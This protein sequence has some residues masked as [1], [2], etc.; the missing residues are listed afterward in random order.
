MKGYFMEA[1]PQQISGFIADARILIVDDEPNIVELLTRLLRI[2]GYKDVRSIRDSRGAMAQI[3]EFHPDLLILDLMMPHIDGF[4]ILEALQEYNSDDGYLPVL[5]ITAND[6]VQARRRAFLGGAIEFLGKP[7]D[8][9]E[10]ILRVRTLLRLRYEYLRLE[11]NAD[12]LREEILDRTRELEDYQLV[13]KEAQIEVIVRLARA[14]EHR[15]D[16]TGQHT[17]RVG[18]IA[19]L[20]AQ[21]MELDVE[22]VESIRRAAPL[23]D[24]GKIGIP[25]AIL[26]KP[27]R[28]DDSEREIMQRHCRIG[29]DLLAGGQSSVVK[30]AERIAM[31]HHERWDGSGYPEQLKGEE[32]DLEGRILAVAD[33]FD[34]LTHARPYKEAWP[35]EKAL[36]E[37]KRSS[38]THFDPTVVEAFL[39][40]PHQELL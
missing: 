2:E 23:H 7:F 3:I 40:L 9:E 4:Q 37:I 5:V 19:S 38:G 17:Q 27:G 15:D 12:I 35:V 14:A 31:T 6:T 20:I 29:A 36:E 30:L 11:K 1:V 21:T 32:I 33:V 18:L 13:L 8:N 28:F 25:D 39:H 34:A 24:V 22:Q 26:L 16:E 10:I